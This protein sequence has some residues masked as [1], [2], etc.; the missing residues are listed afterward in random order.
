MPRI[1]AVEERILGN[2]RKKRQAKRQLTLAE[3]M[4]KRALARKRL[5]PASRTR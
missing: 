4:R 2:A 1:A 3:K 5:A